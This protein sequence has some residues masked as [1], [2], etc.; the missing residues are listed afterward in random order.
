MRQSFRPAYV[1]PAKDSD[2]AIAQCTTFL[3]SAR[4]IDDVTVESLARQYR[5]SIKRAEYLLVV[6][7]Q[8]RAI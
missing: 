5:L 7:R 4:S 6:A 8:R 2:R 3:A 1:P